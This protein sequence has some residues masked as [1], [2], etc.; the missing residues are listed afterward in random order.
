[1]DGAGAVAVA[2]ESIELATF[3]TCP[4]IR[5]HP[6]VVAQKAATPAVLSGERFTLSVG[7]GERLNEHIVGHD[8]DGFFDFWASELRDAVSEC[9]AT[10]SPG[11][12]R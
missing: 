11:V 5:Y 1:M 6:A 2:T 8:Q 4:I 7:A 3:V 10:T 12:V 9:L